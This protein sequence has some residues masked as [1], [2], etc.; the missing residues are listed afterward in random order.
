MAMT[1]I[2]G[3]DTRL[4][5]LGLL[6]L[7]ILE[8]LGELV[9]TRRNARRALARG[10]IEVG[11]AHYPWMVALHTLLLA[12]CP[13]EVFLLDRPFL[14]WLGWPMLGVL[15]ATMGLRYWA[16]S[17]LGERWT[18]TVIVIPG[19]EVVRRGPYKWLRHPNYLA[20]IAEVAALPLVHTAWLSA[21]VFSI[22]NAWVLRERIRT[23][24]RAL[25]EHSFY[26]SAFGEVPRFLPGGR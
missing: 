25:A 3:I 13:L 16:I 15:A 5:Y 8:R 1:E 7:L 22:G 12:A 17:S 21:I 18:T 10:G 24:E 6:G 26:E 23:E 19:E 2:F 11:A 4:L 14:P 20:V 9:I